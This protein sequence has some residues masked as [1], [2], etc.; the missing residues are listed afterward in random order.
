MD[1]AAMRDHDQQSSHYTHQFQ[2]IDLRS[3]HLASTVGKHIGAPSEYLQTDCTCRKL[4]YLLSQGCVSN[5]VVRVPSRHLSVHA[6]TYDS[7]SNNP[8]FIS[9]T[10]SG[11]IY[12]FELSAARCLVLGVVLLYSRRKS[13]HGKKH[14][15]IE[16]IDRY[17]DLYG[18]GFL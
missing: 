9:S 10:L 14:S 13:T 5:K 7:S 4:Q 3:Q 6:I 18:R 11:L 12:L 16:V 15:A 17:R 1:G 2:R 8:F